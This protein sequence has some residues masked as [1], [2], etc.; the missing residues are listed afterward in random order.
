VIR[1]RGK[2]ILWLSLIAMLFSTMMVVMTTAQGDCTLTVDPIEIHN[3]DMSIMGFS[4]DIEVVDVE[5]LYACALTLDYAPYSKQLVARS[6]VEGDFL[7]GMGIE[8]DFVFKIDHFSGE[9]KIG[10]A[11]LGQVPGVSGSGTIATIEFGIAEAGESPLDLVYVELYDSDGEEITFDV[12]NGFYYGPAADLTSAGVVIPPR[13]DRPP[14]MAHWKDVLTF[15]SSVT[16]YGEVDLHVRVK[17]DF[18]RV[19]DSRVTTFWAGQGYITTPRAPEYLY[20]NEYNEALEWDWT[21]PGASV[22]GEPDGNYVESIVADAMSSAYGFE[23]ITLGPGDAIGRVVLEGYCQYPSGAS[24]DMDIDIYTMDFDW[25]GSLYGA[26]TW[27]WVTPRWVGADLSDV[28]PS[29]K[30]KDPTPINN[31]EVLLYNYEGNADNPMRVDALRLRVEF[32]QAYP[33]EPPVFTLAPGETLELDEASWA[34]GKED[35]GFYHGTAT[36]YFSYYYPDELPI[37]YSWVMAETRIPLW[38]WVPGSGNPN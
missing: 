37:P 26:S 10:N 13:E 12:A 8:T 23:D 30:G 31:L 25:I 16:N 9:V 21:N 35:K 1:V 7:Q 15:T 6:V 38:F 28:L 24:E 36:C 3:E 14:G 5:D 34:L 4:L 32:A 20:V 11:R 18:I 33:I 2:N 27:G 22:I 17:Y 19:Q 29:V